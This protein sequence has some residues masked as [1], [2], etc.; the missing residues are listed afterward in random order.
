MGR[1]CNVIPSQKVTICLPQDLLTEVR[2]L[3]WSGVEERVPHGA[4]QKY[5]I[6][7]I[8]DDLARRRKALAGEEAAASAVD[9]FRGK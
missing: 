1:P 2:L 3:L 8:V 5:L 4:W 6:R 7:L 9:R